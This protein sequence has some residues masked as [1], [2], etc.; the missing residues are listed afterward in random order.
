[1]SVPPAITGSVEPPWVGDV[2]HFWFEELGQADWF[3]KSRA[4]DAQIRDRFLQ[5]HEQLVE[6]RGLGVSAPR[7]ILAAVIVLDQFSRNLF[8][9]DARAFSADPIARQLSRTAIAQGIDAKMKNR[10][11]KYFLYLPFEHSEDREDQ[12]LANTMIRQLGNEKWTGYADTH[13]MMIERFGR[14]PHRNEVLKRLSTADELAFL[15]GPVISF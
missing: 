13:R 10:Q 11:E 8:R 1:M 7:E 4:I 3:A 12:A 14:F 2:I 6:H 5:L 9:D 15:E